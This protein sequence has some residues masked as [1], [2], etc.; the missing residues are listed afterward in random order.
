MH[1]VLRFSNPCLVR[2]PRPF[3]TYAYVGSE[4]LREIYHHVA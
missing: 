1:R 4:G 2:N 3:G